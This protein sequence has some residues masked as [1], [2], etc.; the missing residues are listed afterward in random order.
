MSEIPTL[1]NAVNLIAAGL[2]G[3]IISFLFEKFEWFQNLT[4]DR[5]WQV[6][7]GLSVSLPLLAQVALQFIPAET[8]AALEPYWHSVATGFVWWLGSQVTHK[9]FNKR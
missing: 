3:G 5:R 8:W 7:L 1:F 6:I 9:F 2:I 4:G